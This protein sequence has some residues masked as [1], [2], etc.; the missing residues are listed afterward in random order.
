MLQK[1]EKILY[2]FFTQ[3]LEEIYNFWHCGTE[4][5]PTY[6]SLS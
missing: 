5:F 2:Q 1:E 4:Y 6:I 3:K